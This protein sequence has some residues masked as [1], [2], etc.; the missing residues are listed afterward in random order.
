MRSIR[1]V[2]LGDE[3][4]TGAGDPKG[5]GWLGRVQARL[6]KGENVAFF[7]LAMVDENTGDLLERWKSEALKRFSPESE[8]YLVVALSSKDIEAGTTISRSRL[9]LASLLDDAQREGVKTFVVGPTPLGNPE[10]DAEVEHLNAGFYDVVKR[11]QIRY[12]DCF[13]P[14]KDHEGWLGEVTASERNLPGQVGYG[15]IAWLVLNR[16]W[17]EWLGMTEEDQ[18]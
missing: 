6:P 10:Y 12:V 4:L 1:V 18:S 2:I 17:F 14:L 8:N 13:S 7:P 9:N 15:L 5:L 16:G 3:L 11:R